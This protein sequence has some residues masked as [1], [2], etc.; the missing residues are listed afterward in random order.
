MSRERS[1]LTQYEEHWILARSITAPGHLPCELV[2]F[3]GPDMK[4]EDV[5]WAVPRE[6]AGGG[7]VGRS[8]GRSGGPPKLEEDFLE[9]DESSCLEVWEGLR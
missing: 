2:S 3:R 6:R 9:E 4:A 1:W 7:R 8:R 5:W